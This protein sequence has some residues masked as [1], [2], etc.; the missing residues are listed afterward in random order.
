MKQ[1]PNPLFRRQAA[2]AR[3]ENR[4]A[5]DG[6]LSPPSP[7]PPRSSGRRRR[8]PVH[9]RSVSSVLTLPE[10]AT[11]RPWTAV[12]TRPVRPRTGTGRCLTM[13][14]PAA[15]TGT[16]VTVTEPSSAGT[17]GNKR[18]IAEEENRHERQRGVDPDDGWQMPGCR[19]GLKA[20]PV[21]FTRSPA[22][23]AKCNLRETC[24]GTWKSRYRKSPIFNKTR[25]GQIVRGFFASETRIVISAS[26]GKSGRS[27]LP[28][29]DRVCKLMGRG[30]K[31]VS[32]DLFA[33]QF[34]DS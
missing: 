32:S 8:R 27:V 10:E 3:G 23:F 25:V 21:W 30:R 29:E 15:E 33:K 28:Q 20:P 24:P 1:E 12:P 26:L 4:P 11:Q 19:R 31:G 5:L 34:L 13:C 18:S 14:R 22:Y 16:K 7:P 2:G 6:V 17:E 9:G